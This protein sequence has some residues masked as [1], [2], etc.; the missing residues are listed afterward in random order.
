MDELVAAG[1]KE[2]RNEWDVRPVRLTYQ[3]GT[4]ETMADAWSAKERFEAEG[5]D[6]YILPAENETET[7][8]QLLSGAF[9]EEDA[10]LPLPTGVI[11]EDQVQLVVRRGT[12]G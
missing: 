7:V 12:A 11:N 3:I 4:Y 10:A 8:Y 6:C 9:E 2:K 5:V 1:R